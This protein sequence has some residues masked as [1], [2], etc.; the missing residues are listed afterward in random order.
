MEFSSRITTLSPQGNLNILHTAAVR[1]V[2]R[3]LKADSDTPLFKTF[4]RLG[5]L[6]S[7]VSICPERQSEAVSSD[8]DQVTTLEKEGGDPRA[9]NLL[10]QVNHGSWEDLKEKWGQP[11]SYSVLAS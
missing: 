7:L 2:N 10:S 5:D 3:K 9:G 4:L 1:A 6:L 11:Y 8:E